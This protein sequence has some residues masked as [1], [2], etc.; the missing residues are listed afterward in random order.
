MIFQLLCGAFDL[1]QDKSGLIKEYNPS[2][3]E[4]SFSAESVK[5]LV[6]ELSF[7]FYYLLANRRLSYI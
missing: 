4:N 6:P 2:L 5:K 7:K 1:K 3:R